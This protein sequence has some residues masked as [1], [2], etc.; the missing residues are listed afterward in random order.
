MRNKNKA[1]TLI[2]LMVAMAII[3]VLI[4]LTVFGIGVAQQGQRDTDRKNK[5]NEINLLVTKYM[6]TTKA[7]PASTYIVTSASTIHVGASTC[8]GSGTCYAVPVSGSN[9]PGTSTST[10]ATQ[11]QR[12]A[13]LGATAV[14]TVACK[15]GQTGYVISVGLE[16]TTNYNLGSCEPAT[17]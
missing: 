6:E 15:S 11:W 7:T 14:S 2:E 3:G 9:S 10:T 8:P 13:A 17:P 12:Q 4:G 16:G 1:F 5:L